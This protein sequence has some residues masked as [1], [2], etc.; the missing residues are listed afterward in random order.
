MFG[1]FLDILYEKNNF[2]IVEFFGLFWF[3]GK[4]G[5]ILN[6]ICV[7]FIV[8]GIFDVIDI[9]IYIWWIIFLKVFI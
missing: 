6:V 7:I 5:F 4:I 8:V 2:F 1:I 3:V 9:V